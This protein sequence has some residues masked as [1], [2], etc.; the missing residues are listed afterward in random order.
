MKDVSRRDFI[1]YLGAGAVSLITRPRNVLENGILPFDVPSDVVQCYDAGATSGSTINEPVVQVMMDASVTT[2]A[3]VGD[4]GE[5][6]KSLFPG[7]T[8]ASIIGIKV[9]CINSAFPTHPGV[10]NCIT[11]GL[12]RMDFVGTLFPLN[13]VIVWDRTDSEMTACGY[14]VYTGS[15][16]ARVRYVGSDH[17]GFGY[18]TLSFNVNGVTSHPSKILSQMCDYIIDAA[19]L[20]THSQATVTLTMKNHYGSVN[21]PGSLQHASGCSPAIPALNQQIR[22]LVTPNGIQ[23]L[24]LIDGLF[25][26]Y[27]GG[28]GGSPNF[29]PKLV[30]LSRDPVACDA[31]GQN[32]INVERQAHGLSQLS[33]AQITAAAQSP[34]DLGT[35]DINLI[36]VLNPT[37]LVD[38]PGVGVR[39]RGLVVTPEP[40]R[41]PATVSFDLPH[42]SAVRIDLVDQTGRAEAR[43][44]E[45]RL[46]R[47]RHRL[48]WNHSGRITPGTHFLRMQG[49]GPTR[50]CKV[51][52]LE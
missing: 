44:F 8:A 27:S 45:G 16:P 23:K 50:L 1:K 28:P 3:G 48:A 47:G 22:D 49:S 20:R 39:E 30:I 4:V 35:T 19:V 10:V 26:L 9:N 40:L 6:W 43:V 46:N 21:N 29:N 38:A 18:D 11:N 24:Y 37:G 13:N 51:V 32:V 2:L 5:A 52:V 12:G 14:T 17:S 33:A 36:E 15:D 7:I 42:S 25:G 34:Y 41:G 31:Q